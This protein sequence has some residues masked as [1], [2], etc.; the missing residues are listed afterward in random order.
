M[1]DREHEFACVADS[2]TK[3]GAKGRERE[4]PPLEPMAHRPSVASDG[5][6]EPGRHLR[7]PWNRTART[8]AGRVWRIE[9]PTLAGRPFEGIC[10]RHREPMLHRARDFLK[11]GE[12][13]LLRSL[14]PPA[15]RKRKRLRLEK[16]IRLSMTATGQR[17]DSGM[18]KKGTHHEVDAL[19]LITRDRVDAFRQLPVGRSSRLSPIRRDADGRDSYLLRQDRRGRAFQ[20]PECAAAAWSNC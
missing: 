9:A 8:A 5:S 13:C 20:A 19:A 1:P 12:T 17:A 16:T 18:R 15:P 4:G 2:E 6:V 7:A 3:T 10:Q 14:P 11:S